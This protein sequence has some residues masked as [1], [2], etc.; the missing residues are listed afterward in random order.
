[1]EVLAG[2]DLTGFGVT[3]GVRGS[4]RPLVALAWVALVAVSCAPA[5]RPGHRASAVPWV[6]RPAPAYLPPPQP[7]PAAAYPPCRARQL[8]GR[9]GRGGPAAGIVHQEVRLTNRGDR[10]CTL[11]GGPAA[12]TG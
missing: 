12:V 11:S 6:N 4:S 1:M 5:V 3:G 7:R 2:N 9:P 10:P 8:A